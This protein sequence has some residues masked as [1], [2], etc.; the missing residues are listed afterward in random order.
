LKQLKQ[1]LDEAGK[2]GV[3]KDTMTEMQAIVKRVQRGRR[4]EAK[5][6]VKLRGLLY[7][8]DVQELSE[9]LELVRERPEMLG[10]AAQKT[11]CEIEDKVFRKA[12]EEQH[13]KWLETELE[14]AAADLSCDKRRLQQLIDQARNLS[15]VVPPWVFAKINGPWEED[16]KSSPS[17]APAKEAKDPKSRMEAFAKRAEEKAVATLD[18]FDPNEPTIDDLLDAKKAVE[19]AKHKKVP[20]EAM[21]KLQNRLARIEMTFGPRFQVEAKLQDIFRIAEK[22]CPD[23]FLNEAELNETEKVEE[24]KELLEQALRWEC[25]PDIVGTAQGLLERSLGAEELRREADLCI[26]RALAR[27]L[28]ADADLDLLQEAI[29][30]GRRCG[31]G[32]LHADRELQR[33][34]HDQVQREAAEAE[35]LEASKGAGCK[36]R[37]Q[38]GGCDPARHERRRRAEESEGGERPPAA[39]HHPRGEMCAGRRQHQKSH[40]Y[41]AEGTVEV[42]ADHGDGEAPS[43][44][45]SRFGEARR[46]LPGLHETILDCAEPAKR[47]RG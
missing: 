13:Q 41:V 42:P 40:A 17:R 36:G 43:A 28:R 33:L 11:L 3:D 24:L 23:A 38:A 21:Q 20:E 31:A 15:L 34:R 44:V 32:T 39:P 12:Q 25:D 27:P 19:G 4:A 7:T 9:Q 37:R 46:H 30:S 16:A 45:D 5:A 29:A 22:R 47:G 35:L 14:A 18:E 10:P 8:E 26:R 2:R 6:D 1:A